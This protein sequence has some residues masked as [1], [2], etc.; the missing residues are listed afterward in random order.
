MSTQVAIKT[1]FKKNLSKE[2]L[3]NIHNEIKLLYHLDHPGIVKYYETYDDDNYIYLV[4]E[5]L[6][7][8]DL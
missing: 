3:V 7:G 2:E 8:Q 1:I 5:Y 4:M 6:E